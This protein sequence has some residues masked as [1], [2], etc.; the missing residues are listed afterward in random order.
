MIT[1]DE[2]RQLLRYDPETGA[3]AWVKRRKG[4]RETPGTVNPRG[5]LVVTLNAKHYLVQRLAFLLHTGKWPE[6]VA[7]HE[8][9]DKLNNR[10][11]NLRDVPQVHNV[12]NQRRA[13][14]DNTLGVLGI[15]RSKGGR[16]A[17]RIRVKGRRIGLG[18]FDTKELA[19]AAYVAAKREL[20]K[21][22]TI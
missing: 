6:H 5:Y 22:C 4:Q 11:R 18:T 3:F 9:G 20:H 13:R 10:W 7:E 1:A 2:A 19:H 21:G 15:E 17:A 16:F 8:D 12:E 14:S